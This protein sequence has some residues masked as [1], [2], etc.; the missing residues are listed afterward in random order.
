M[1]PRLTALAYSEVVD[2]TQPPR[3][4]D[5]A[6]QSA[7]QGGEAACWAHELC[8]GCGAPAGD[9]HRSDCPER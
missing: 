1:R 2:Q 7:E 4:S 6:P 8:P 3:P 5:D 9:R